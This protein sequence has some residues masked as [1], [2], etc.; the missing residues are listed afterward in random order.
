MQHL[1]E[2]RVLVGNAVGDAI[3]AAED[4]KEDLERKRTGWMAGRNLVGRALAGRGIAG[5]VNFD[6]PSEKNLATKQ[7][8]AMLLGLGREILLVLKLLIASVV[9]LCVMSFIFIVKK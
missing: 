9:V 6:S 3:G 8:V 2:T 4:R 1:V 5:R 7:Q